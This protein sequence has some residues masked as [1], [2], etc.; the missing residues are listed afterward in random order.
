MRSYIVNHRRDLDMDGIDGMDGFDIDGFD[1]MDGEEPRSFS[2][3]FLNSSSIRLIYQLRS[4]D[5]I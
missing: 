1:G 2:C 4:S 5:I 3:C